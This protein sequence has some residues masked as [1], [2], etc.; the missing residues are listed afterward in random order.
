MKKP[1]LSLLACFLAA[2]PLLADAAHADGTPRANSAAPAADF[3]DGLAGGPD[4]WEVTGV[5][6][7]DTL[8]LRAGPS[9]RER[10][11]GDLPNGAVM[12]NLGCTL[13]SGQRW[14]RVERLE[15]RGTQGWVAG[16]YLRESS[17]QP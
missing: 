2:A 8:H 3:A 6:S 17:Y 10:V 16:R 4:F 15:N 7:G 9:A 11:V 13:T 1:A 14:C 5:A 12:R